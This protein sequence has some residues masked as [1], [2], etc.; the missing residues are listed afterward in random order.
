[1]VSL[2]GTQGRIIQ[3]HFDGN[4]LYIKHS[5]LYEFREYDKETV[6][7]FLRWLMNEPIGD[8]AI[9]GRE[10]EEGSSSSSQSPVDIRSSI[11]R[12]RAISLTA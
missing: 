1:M 12:L 6:D 2:I 4:K 8:T 7:L 5:R 9:V 3:A 10:E 11:E